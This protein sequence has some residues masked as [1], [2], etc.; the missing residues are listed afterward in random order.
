MPELHT[1]SQE[2][3]L[4]QHQ[5][6]E[7]LRLRERGGRGEEDRL[8][9]A[10]SFFLGRGKIKF[11]QRAESQHTCRMFLVGCMDSGSALMDHIGPSGPIHRNAGAVCKGHSQLLDP[12][13]NSSQFQRAPLIMRCTGMISLMQPVVLDIQTVVLSFFC[14]L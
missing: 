2:N 6:P 11:H 4:R 9:A 8:E 12:R 7:A 5:E 3:Q 10:F 13:I 1:R 14:P